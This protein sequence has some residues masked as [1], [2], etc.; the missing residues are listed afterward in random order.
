MKPALW[1]WL[2]LDGERFELLNLD[3]PEVAAEI[4]A[5]MK[6]GVDVYYDNRWRATELFARHL[7]AN[8]DLVSNKDVLVLGAGVG[9]ETLVIGR[10]CRRLYVND[11]APVALELCAR[12]LTH[13]GVEHFT[14]LP[15]CYEEIKL[16]PVDLIVGS[17]LI[18]NT[19]TVQAMGQILTCSGA[20]VLL[21]NEALPAWRKLVAAGLRSAQKLFEQKAATC[22]LF[23]RPQDHLRS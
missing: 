2:D 14:T 4:I 6:A 19:A 12:Q 7:Q 21:M 23:T 3:H 9:L 16:P 5:E 11:L 13:N 15:G 20:D 17:F 22:L 1:T 18:Y 8:P 10:L